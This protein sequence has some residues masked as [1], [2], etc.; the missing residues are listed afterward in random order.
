M[1]KARIVVTHAGPGSIMP[2]L[3]RGNIPVVLAR[4]KK[5]GEAVDDHQKDFAARLEAEGLILYAEDAADLEDKLRN[6]DVLVRERCSAGTAVEREKHLS[7][8][9]QRLDSL[10]R[11]LV[12]A[13]TR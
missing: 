10:C 6:Y 4:E 11:E 5:F 2:V 9:I 12:S 1:E 13:K 8:F 7:L 3:Y